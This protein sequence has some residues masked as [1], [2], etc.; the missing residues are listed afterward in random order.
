MKFTLRLKNDK[1]FRYVLKKGKFSKN[2]EYLTIHCTKNKGKINYFG[3]CVSKKNGNSVCRNK[4]KRWARECYKKEEHELLKGYNIVVLFRKDT[5][6]DKVNYQLLYEDFC[7]C[8]KEINL[9][10]KNI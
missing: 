1:I 4:L 10:D 8:L 3:I 5:T 9:Y 2:G 7:N 6:I